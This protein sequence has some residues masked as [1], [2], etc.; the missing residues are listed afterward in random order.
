M[1]RRDDEGL[2]VIVYGVPITGSAVRIELQRIVRSA[3]GFSN[4]MY[5]AGA[6]CYPTRR[7]PMGLAA[8]RACPIKFLR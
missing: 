6:V 4:D 1:A 8:S 7:F 5:E 3:L 2:R